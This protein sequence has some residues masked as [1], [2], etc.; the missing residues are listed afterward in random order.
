MSTLKR[1]KV[2]FDSSV[3]IA[4]LASPEGA[5]NMLLSLCEMGLIIPVISE[6]VVTEVVRNIEK[7]LPHCLPHYHSLFKILPFELADPTDELLKE[8][9]RL[10]NKKDADIL[11]AAINSKVDYLVSLDKHFFE[12][13]FSSLNIKAYSP[14][15]LLKNIDFV[16]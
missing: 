5:S 4:S 15:E 8:A 12:A 14:G 1:G 2:F 7:K 10:I 3:L 16:T 6:K 13:D 11:A 9:E